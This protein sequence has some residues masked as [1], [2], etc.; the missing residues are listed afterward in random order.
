VADF[1]G[2]MNFFDARVREIVD[3]MVAIDA[4]P[5]GNL[6]ISA[7]SLAF[8]I[9][10]KSL[11]AIRPEKI[12]ISSAKP[13][14]GNAVKGVIDDTAYLGDRS[15]FYVRVNGIENPVAVSAQNMGQSHLSGGSQQGEIWLNWSDD[16]IVLLNAD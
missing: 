5:L 12:T 3:G 6:T 15:H 16:A 1:I 7:G 2:N 9:G 14:N 8:S 10:Q 4:G 11:V 13:E